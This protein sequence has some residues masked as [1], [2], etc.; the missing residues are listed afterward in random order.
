MGCLDEREHVNDNQ[1]DDGT[2]DYHVQEYM[3]EMMNAY[4]SAPDVTKN[5]RYIK[6]GYVFDKKNINKLLR[7][8]FPIN[9]FILPDDFIETIEEVPN[10]WISNLQRL[11]DNFS[12]G[13]DICLFYYFLYRDD[14][15][16]KRKLESM[17]AGLYCK[18]QA[19][20]ESYLIFKG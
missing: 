11:E 5:D 20:C 15:Y 18:L 17:R 1:P 4:L 8:K 19:A 6:I 10:N 12:D 9:E 3:D 13:M 2:D 14:F 7:Q 16:F